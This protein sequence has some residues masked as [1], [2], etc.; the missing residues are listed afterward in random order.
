MEIGA[1]LFIFLSYVGVLRW[2]LMFLLKRAKGPQI[3][4]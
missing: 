4:T 1:L 3:E 2:Y